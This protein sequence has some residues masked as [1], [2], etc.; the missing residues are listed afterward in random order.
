MFAIAAVL[1]AGFVYG[2]F[3]ARQF[4]R[5]QEPDFLT[6]RELQK[7][8]KNPHPGGLLGLKLERFR[9]TP[10]ISNEA[11]FEGERPLQHMD[12]QMGPY[13]T[14]A[15]WNIQESLNIKDAIAVFTSPDQFRAMI[16][17]G[18][19]AEGS[20][21]YKEILRQRERL[22]NADII[23][24][25]EMDVG[26]KR[27]GYINAA[28]ELA[29]ALKMNYAFGDE[30]LELD[31]WA[32]GLEKIY[33][34]DGKTV[35]KAR[36]E[37]AMADPLRYKGA[38]GSA[39]LS[40]YPIKKVQVFQLKYQA[41]DWYAGEKAEY[42]LTEKTRGTGSEVLFQTPIKNQIKT[43]TRIYFR[44]DLGVPELPE[45]TL[46]IIN[47]HLEIKCT[48]KQ[49]E[50]ELAEILSYMKGI[51]HPV[52]MVG[53]YNAAPQDLSA[54]SIK[55]VVTRTIQNPTTWLSAAITYLSPQAL[56]INTTRF[57]GNFTKNLQD[58]LAPD[59]SVIFP[60]PLHDLF[61]MIQ[62]YRFS[63]GG[64]FDFRGDPTRSIN[65]KDGAL[66]NSNERGF[67]GF[68]STWSVKRPISIIGKYRLDWL[69]VKSFLKDPYAK[70]GT[71]RVAP[72]FGETLEEMNTS[73]KA[74]ISD[75]HP[76]VV[77]IPFQEPRIK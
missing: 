14:L 59:I 6:F 2:F 9:R 11:Y 67:K 4:I 48:P 50:R 74:R 77:D 18:E 30:Q 31:P 44:V 24:L 45:K 13:L 29:K 36:T 38:F 17:P 34:A 7:L 19:A 60:N 51:K 27:S 72:H 21:G 46:T 68:K 70:A 42:G 58:P 55:R 12:S 57:A 37:E 69:F 25:Q 65:G 56:I 53:D 40:R 32:L 22:A 71:Y 64:A 62:N 47:I 63:D 66:A 26:V 23:V 16:D 10:I 52:I 3:Y 20:S 8:Y 54:T 41:Y 39:V 5:Y 35:D 61:A 33:Q 73:L 28:G 75:H 43:G 15:S 76:S 1:C 49:R